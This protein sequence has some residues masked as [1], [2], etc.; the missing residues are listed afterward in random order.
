M[1]VTI[2]SCNYI[3][4][5]TLHVHCSGI[6]LQVP[7]VIT[8]VV[9]GM[10]CEASI[11]QLDRTGQMAMAGRLCDMERVWP[12][13]TLRI[14]HNVCITIT[15]GQLDHPRDRGIYMHVCVCRCV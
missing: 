11:T 9:S 4:S 6:W 7:Y 13:G 15:V 14:P 8:H 5:I 2:T 3:T 1:N 12:K 10:Y